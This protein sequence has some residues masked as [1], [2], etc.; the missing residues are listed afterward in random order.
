[1]KN[2]LIGVINKPEFVI[3]PSRILMGAVKFGNTASFEFNLNANPTQAS[4]V[5]AVST[6]SA[7]NFTKGH[8]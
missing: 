6:P 7:I 2:F 1:M 3:G 8:K 5:S 4:L